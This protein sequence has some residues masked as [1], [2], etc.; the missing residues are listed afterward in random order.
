MKSVQKDEQIAR[1]RRRDALVPGVRRGIVRYCVLAVDTSAAMND[2][3]MKPSRGI[4]VLGMC[5][6]FI[7]E[8]FDQNP[9]AHMAI[10][11]TSNG[12]AEVVAP[13]GSSPKVLCSSLSRK[14]F[15]LNRPGP[16]KNN[17]EKIELRRSTARMSLSV[18]TS[19]RILLG[20]VLFLWSGLADKPFRGD[21]SLQNLL[22]LSSKLLS[23]IPPYGSKEVIVVFGSL[24]TTDPGDI[25]STVASLREANI[26]CSVVG[27]AAEVHVLGQVA[28][29]TLV[30][31]S[32]LTNIDT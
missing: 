1:R 12:M 28:K 2:T 16:E 26:K 19:F 3:D 15:P 7:R 20:I 5:E 21:A 22:K 32:F 17:K 29:R 23:P 14:S 31:M 6:E 4:A 9:I 13:I 10:V 25:M 27:L 8:F 24:S 30:S 18:C 11:S